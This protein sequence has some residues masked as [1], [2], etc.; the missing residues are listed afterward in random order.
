MR[1]D[2]YRRLLEHMSK[3][4]LKFRPA[5]EMERILDIVLD[6][7][8]AEILLKLGHMPA[9]HGPQSMA[10]KTDMPLQE[11]RTRLENL[12]SRGAIARFRIMGRDLYALLPLMPGFFELT[13]MKDD[14]Y[15]PDTKQELRELWSRYKQ[16][17]LTHELTDYPTLAM[18]VIP[19]N[20][21]IEPLH[22]VLLQD[23]VKHIVQKAGKI[24]L[25][26]CACRVT[27]Q[28]CDLPI[29]TCFAFNS[30]AWFMIQ[31]GFARE[32]SVKKALDVL[33][34][35]AEVGLV[36]AALNSRND[37]MILCNCCGCCCATMSAITKMNK[38]QGVA[39]SSVSAVI[40]AERC[41]DCGV[42]EKRCWVSA[43]SVVDDV[44]TVDAAKC[45]GCGLCIQTC[46]ND[47]ISMQPR[48][49]FRN[50]APRSPIN[51]LLRMT[52]ERG[53][54]SAMFKAVLKEM[55]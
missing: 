10:R 19:I 7:Q 41:E 48:P 42:C 6:E 26:N 49:G 44:R 40:D 53:V 5:E 20:Q 33:H 8:D 54:G 17:Y 35:A 47:A 30:F 9:F 55:I 23:D 36:H 29:D 28:N 2:V 4:P 50:T 1:E 43:I 52:G 12:A 25:G 39:P 46:P 13:F 37:P 34:E 27:E 38:E 22:R 45:I 32:V 16:N 51:L 11:I 18:R 15:P 14:N 3:A 21:S 24:S 31:N